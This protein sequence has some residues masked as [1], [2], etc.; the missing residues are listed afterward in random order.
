MSSLVIA[1]Q[2]AH[3]RNT[4]SE[5]NPIQTVEVFLNNDSRKGDEEWSMR[6]GRTVEPWAERNGG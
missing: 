4:I 1:S 6:Q 3:C 2:G 5:Q